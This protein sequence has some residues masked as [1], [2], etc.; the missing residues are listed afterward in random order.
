MP[1]GEPDLPA[2]DRWSDELTLAE[3]VVVDWERFTRALVT[4]ADA[5]ERL[6]TAMARA[7]DLA[8]RTR[9][10]VAALMDALEGGAANVPH[11]DA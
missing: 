9:E 2:R 3:Q 5:G 1:N 10:D 6:R 7:A 8:A 11:P 4:A